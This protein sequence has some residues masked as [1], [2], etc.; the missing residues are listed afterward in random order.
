M[1][2][3]YLLNAHYT[4]VFIFYR[5]DFF[6]LYNCTTNKRNYFAGPAHDFY[7]LSNVT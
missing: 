4:F 5:K 1:L 2:Y 7:Q 6:N 3:F